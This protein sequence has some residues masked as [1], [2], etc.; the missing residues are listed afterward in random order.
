MFGDGVGDEITSNILR[1]TGYPK[2]LTAL[3][4]ASIAII[5]LTKI[6]LNARPIVNMLEVIVGIHQ[7]LKQP[8]VD[9]DRPGS[10][11]AYRAFVKVSVSVFTLLTFFV[12]SILFPAFDSIMA[13]MGSTLCFTICIM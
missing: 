11:S 1:T 7:P 2:V 6:P 9:M 4:C 13:F 3:M 12:V 8:R 5:P 10:G